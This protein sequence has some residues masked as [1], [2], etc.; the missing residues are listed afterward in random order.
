MKSAYTVMQPL[1]PVEGGGQV[2]LTDAWF[3][4]R[5]LLSPSST[6]HN[7]VVCSSLIDDALGA[8][9]S[10]RFVQLPAAG[11]ILCQLPPDLLDTQIRLAIQREPFL[12][13]IEIH[14]QCDSSPPIRLRLLSGEQLPLCL[15]QPSGAEAGLA[16]LSRVYGPFDA[17]T[18][19]GPFA[20]R[21]HAAPLFQAATAEL[22]VARG[23]RSIRV[24]NP[25]DHPLRI[26]LHVRT[27]RDV[28]LSESAFLACL[29]RQPNFSSTL[30]TIL[31]DPSSQ[32]DQDPDAF[33]E[34][35]N[36][37]VPFLTRLQLQYRASLRALRGPRP[38]N[39]S[40]FWSR[41]TQR[42]VFSR[43]GKPCSNVN[44]WKR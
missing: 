7:P 4:T 33:Q 19:G 39:C 40:P 6:P 13:P 42:K 21:R 36:H 35:R 12:S 17:G 5:T 30:L 2:E 15:S 10:G 34:L 22:N 9:S 20:S 27:S 32:T 44:G 41:P 8:L 28:Q 24:T 11:H 23:T 29:A 18:L 26:C 25:T 38:M 31:R 37:C 14:V 3:V 43:L 1:L 16:A